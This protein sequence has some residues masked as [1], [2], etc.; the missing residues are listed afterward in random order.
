MEGD[1]SGPCPGGFYG[2]REK[3]RSNM[4]GIKLGEGKARLLWVGSIA[5]KGGGKAHIHQGLS[6]DFGMTVMEMLHLRAQKNSP[7]PNFIASF[8]RLPRVILHILLE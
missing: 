5:P 1:K 4:G 7:W 2:S 6:F 8:L 3:G